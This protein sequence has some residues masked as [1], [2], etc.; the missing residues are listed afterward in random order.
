MKI[1]RNLALSSLSIVSLPAFIA[2]QI[3]ATQMPDFVVLGYDQ[4]FQSQ[5]PGI[6]NRFIQDN[7][8]KKLDIEIPIEEEHKPVTQKEIKNFQITKGWTEYYL[9]E[10]EA[11]RLNETLSQPKPIIIIC[12]TASTKVLQDTLRNCPPNSIHSVILINP[13][14]YTPLN[15]D[16]I[17]HRVYNFY[18]KAPVALTDIATSIR[19]YTPN[20]NGFTVQADRAWSKIVNIRCIRESSKGHDED[21]VLTSDAIGKLNIPAL[22]AIADKNY[23]CNWDLTAV[24]ARTKGDSNYTNMNIPL[25]FLNRELEISG[26]E[27][28]NTAEKWHL[29]LSPAQLEILQEQLD[30]ENQFHAVIT[31]PCYDS[32]TRKWRCPALKDSPAIK[33]KTSTTVEATTFFVPRITGNQPGQTNNDG[34]NLVAF[35]RC[36]N[37]ESLH[38]EFFKIDIGGNL[39]DASHFIFLDKNTWIGNKSLLGSLVSTM[40][41]ISTLSADPYYYAILKLRIPRNNWQRIAG[42][43]FS[44]LF[45][46]EP[47][48]ALTTGLIPTLDD[49]Q[50]IRFIAFADIQKQDQLYPLEDPQSGS[51]LYALAQVLADNEK[52]TYNPATYQPNS[53]YLVVGDLVRNGKN[54]NSWFEV[55][56]KL[57]SIVS[58]GYLTRSYP[59]SLLSAAIGTHDFADVDWSLLSFYPMKPIHGYLFN[60]SPDSKSRQIES[61]ALEFASQQ[62]V[63]QT[64]SWFDRGRVRFIHL[65][66][67]TE[68]ETTPVANKGDISG[69]TKRL[70]ETFKGAAHPFTFDP[71][72]I[73]PQFTSNLA[74]AVADRA[75]GLIDFIIV[76]GHA[77]LATAPQ[78]EHLHKGLLNS[79]IDNDFKTEAKRQFAKVIIQ[80]MATNGVDL[81]LSGHNHQYDRCRIDYKIQPA[82]GQNTINGSLPAVTLGLGTVLRKPH[83]LNE[84]PTLA[85]ISTPDPQI[86]MISITSERFISGADSEKA[87]GQ[88]MSRIPQGGSI[89]PAYLEC[90]TQ[91]NI[92]R[93]RLL[94]RNNTILDEFN[95]P[96]RRE[97]T[98]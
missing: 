61:N 9:T 32:V 60:F 83:A 66:Y 87:F 1:L 88:Y 35:I 36:K 43:R 67:T 48:G 78:Y 97:T 15:F 19:K 96:S 14:V 13:S 74:A 52:S 38:N 34:I 23:K 24:V 71:T 98:K 41:Y 53:L 7:I 51:A 29:T 22:I 44:I 95:I 59:F 8:F 77:P 2:E 89:L 73:L 40:P 4:K 25:L 91:G 79:F 10:Q 63:N 90:T 27:V 47:L 80:E 20:D 62:I 5:S 94:T 55:L 92:L 76:Y 12:D 21:V 26:N 39:Y 82:Q 17:S 37:R 65:P 75:A 85:L 84:I 31:A 11:R 70:F 56:S 64:N 54:S 33:A 18:S 16:A 6:I 3:S 68:E 72:E 45:N 57:N 28:T 69:I 49:R 81:Y 50:D 93:C 30:N 86:K 42:Q 58:N 46:N